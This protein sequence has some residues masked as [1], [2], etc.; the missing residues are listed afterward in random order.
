MTQGNSRYSGRGLLMFSGSKSNDLHQRGAGVHPSQLPWDKGSNS[1]AQTAYFH[2]VSPVSPPFG[3]P[4][5]TRVCEAFCFPAAFTNTG[6]A[7]GR[8]SQ[9]G[10]VPPQKRALP[11]LP[12][13]AKKSSH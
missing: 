3:V 10:L 4:S 11:R 9:P 1:T 7:E 5:G 8:S 6:K 13:A 12:R 2:D